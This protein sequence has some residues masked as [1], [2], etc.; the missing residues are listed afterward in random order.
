MLQIKER[1]QRVTSKGQITL[2]IS[3]R[4]R[5]KTDNIS[6]RTNGISIEIRPVKLA[7]PIEKGEE[8]IFD[9][10]RDN[11]GRGMPIDKFI[12]AL[13]RSIKRDERARQTHK[14]RKS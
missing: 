2:P 7:F 12:G 11:G 5:Y 4:R 3:W 9:A 6:V 10:V 1:I 14:K 8:V 13:D